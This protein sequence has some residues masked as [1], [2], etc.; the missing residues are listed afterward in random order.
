ESVPLKPRE[1]T[2]MAIE[3]TPPQEDTL[4]G[5]PSAAE[6]F[7]ESAAVGLSDAG[8]ADIIEALRDEDGARIK[9]YLDE[10]GEAD[11]AELLHKIG[12]E[13]RRQFFA[14]YGDLLDPYVF[15]E[16]DS[17]LSGKALSA[18]PAYKVAAIIS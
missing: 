1:E 3:Q 16:L 8:I 17:A 7:E 5:A 10:M 6:I 12:D 18:M 9:A 4:D 13:D 11:I 15:S 14:N 2:L